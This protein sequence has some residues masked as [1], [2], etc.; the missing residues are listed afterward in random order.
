MTP[1]AHMPHP[2]LTVVIPFHNNHPFLPAC[3]AS[4]R[5]HVA[6]DHEVVIIDDGS[7]DRDYLMS[8]GK[9][10]IRILYLD[11]PNGPSK[12][13]NTGIASARGDYILF[14]DS[15]DTLEQDPSTM[16]REQTAQASR[17][18]ADL[19]I[20]QETGIPLVQALRSK[21]PFVTTLADEP[22]LARQRRFC[23]ILYRRAFLE[24]NDI[25]FHEDIQHG[26]DLILLA[27]AISKAQ[28]C[29]VAEL[30]F[31]HYRQRENS[32]TNA[33]LTRKLLEDRIET[34]RR[35]ATSFEH[36]PEAHALKCYSMLLNNLHMANRVRM[37]TS[38]AEAL[39]FT[40]QLGQWVRDVLHAPAF[41]P[42]GL[43]RYNQPWDDAANQ[44]FQAFLAN[45]APEQVLF[46]VAALYDD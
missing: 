34:I 30:P 27:Q 23:S 7:E 29:Y 45:T 15:D 25:R 35:I 40:D 42:K 28:N 26:E 14:V 24:E 31:Y 1:K 4:I 5:E 17:A 18:P 20:G 22:R 39:W 46:M 16:I 33:G 19:L 44:I 11:G 37:T 13:R 9:P 8:L 41:P 6:C 38:G 32:L 12:A 3:L 21:A 2:A 36:F 43:S 10:D